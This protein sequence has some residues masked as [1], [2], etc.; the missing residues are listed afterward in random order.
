MSDS[1]VIFKRSKSKPGQRA[2]QK[3]PDGNNVTSDFTS[4]G[5]ESPITLASKLKNKAKRAKPKSKLSFGGDD[6]EVCVITVLKEFILMCGAMEGVGEVFQ[7][8]KSNL[9]RKLKL[10]TH[11]ASPAY[12]LYIFLKVGGTHYIT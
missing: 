9:S 7:V 6:D 5:D 2:R 1:P 8:R 4:Q 3:S 11:P 10:G 12:A